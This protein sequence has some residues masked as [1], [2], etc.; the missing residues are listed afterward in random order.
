VSRIL[1]V[2]GDN[3]LYAIMHA[4][5]YSTSYRSDEV[6]RGGI[7]G[8]MNTLSNKINNFNPNTCV[9][10]WDGERSRRRLA[11]HPGY[12]DGRV[13]DETFKGRFTNQKSVL[14][15]VLEFTGVH[16]VI[17]QKEADDVIGFICREFVNPEDV[18]TIYSND[19][20]FYQLI[21]NNI[22]VYRSTIGEEVNADN[23][24][25][26]VKCRVENFLLMRAILGDKSDNIEKVPM[27]GETSILKLFNE[28]EAENNGNGAIILDQLFRKILLS[29]NNRLHNINNNRYLIERNLSLMNLSEEPFSKGDLTSLYYQLKRDVR[30]SE[31]DIRKFIIE[32]EADNF[33]E[34]FTTWSI[35]YRCLRPF[36][37][38]KRLVG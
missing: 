38:N 17:L 4:V 31:T 6:Y 9:V 1:L 33:S 7:L 18:V 2:D 13:H 24:Q 8:V 20:D 10:V 25:R 30:F 3:L 34:K 11:I 28:I 29:K 26:I 19:K 12:K 36:F 22:S 5:D 27:V 23:F 35:N 15:R 32:W 14:I 16:S 21:R 37:S